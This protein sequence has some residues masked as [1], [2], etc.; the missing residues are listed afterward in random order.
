MLQ[1]LL[2]YIGYSSDDIA[3]LEALIR[4]LKVLERTN[5][6]KIW[7][8]KKIEPGTD[9]KRVI[10][11]NLQAADIIL[12]LVSSNSISSDIFYEEEMPVALKRQEA[13]STCTIPVI[14]LPCHW[15]ETPLGGIQALPRNGKPVSTWDSPDNAYAHIVQE[16]GIIVVNILAQQAAKPKERPYNVPAGY[17]K[18]G[19]SVHW[20]KSQESQQIMGVGSSLGHL[21]DKMLEQL[22]RIKD[23]LTGVPTGF[24]ALD[25]IT[26]G[27][28][29]SDLI[30]LAARPGMGKTSFVLSMAKN[31]AI[32]F[33]KNIAIF[34][35]EMSSLQV[36]QRLISMEAEISSNKFRNG[37]FEE[38]EWPQLHSAIE[39]ISEAPIFIDDKSDITI[40]ELCD[41]CRHLKMQHNIQLIIIDYLQLI[42]GG[43]GRN[44]EQEVSDISRTL[45]G[46]A[47]ELN[48]PIIALSQLSRAVEVRGG[49]K[50]PQLSDLRESG[51]LEQD[52]SLVCF[53]YRPEYY[54]I[55]E[56][57][58][59]NSLKGVAEIIIAKHRHGALDTVKLRFTDQFAR[60][61]NLDDLPRDTFEKP[62][63]PANRNVITRPS[64]MNDDEDI[65]F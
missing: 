39:R 16:L 44:R 48:V 26:S 21:A 22:S 25:R 38:Y 27:W 61:S 42:S 43:N 3:Y 36:S 59:G 2:L 55:M 15:E 20:K 9:R 52:A 51:S 54:Q 40:F 60:F 63:A 17:Y 18:H 14:V 49:T 1:P 8:D 5:K 53:I 37:Q 58:E 65:P 6:V 31:V 23:G 7:Y 41:K 47:K 12:L 62:F 46:L 33:K 28:Q 32:D 56:D 34:S 64:R 29:P 11:D 35:L 50:R 24:P 57:E 45:K 30:I 19:N 4:H 10:N 13:G